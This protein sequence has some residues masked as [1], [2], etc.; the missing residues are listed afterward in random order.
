MRFLPLL[1]LLACVSVP[2]DP[3]VVDTG[4][5]PVTET[6]PTD[7]PDGGEQGADLMIL[8]PV[9][10]VDAASSRASAVGSRD[11]VIVY[12]G[13]AAGA[14]AWT[15]DGT[16]VVELAADQ[17][18]LPGLHDMHVHILE[19]FHPAITCVLNPAGP[20][21]MATQMSRCDVSPG[22]DWVLG[23]GHT[24]EDLEFASRNP[25][26]YLDD[27]FPNTPVAVM[28]L[29]SHS[30][31]VNSEALRRLGI[32]GDTAD[33]IGGVISRWSGQADGLL[34]D[35][36]GELPFDMALEANPAL[37][38][39]NVEALRAGL[40][41]A[42]RH[43]V[44]SLSDARAY[45]KRGYV[46]AWEQVRDE[47][48]LTVRASVGLWAYPTM[49]TGE[50]IDTLAAMYSDEPGARLRFN[51]VKLYSDG[52]VSNTT[53]AL[54]DPYSTETWAGSR[55]LNYFDEARLT[56]M[57]RELTAVGFDLHVHT[58]GDRAVHEALNAIEATAG[59]TARPPRHRLTHVE[60]VAPA[61]VSR[62]AKLGVIA[63]MQTSE[64]TLPEH[65]HDNDVFLGAD[66]VD[67]RSWPLR[68][69]HESGAQLTLS[70]DYDVGDMS[71]FKGMARAID[72][73]DQSLPDVDAAIRAYT[74]NAA[75]AMRQEDRVGSIEVG[76]LADLV[77]VD[78]DPVSTDALAGTKVLWTLVEGEPVYRRAGF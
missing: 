28:E 44:T 45:W 30:A 39:Q 17:V 8:G 5:P 46:E 11:G 42:N 71:P 70:S 77:V 13:D 73:G 66:R 3:Q 20:A 10:T 62:F 68:D 15:D 78:R 32:D 55:G 22:T 26:A 23:W 2:V 35:S 34:L 38:A 25:K 76:K 4:S 56:R 54:L 37:M 24:I 63:D 7:R 6:P 72:R 40:A 50:L 14:G 43:G 1:P 33:P 65:L 21:N 53:A 61:D 49:D 64:W 58:I 31:W 12:V 67:E 36:A 74:I 16:E 47:G 9:Y 51:Q 41:F 29:T 19:A 18:V 60:M 75:A 27:H 57:A 52:L 69:L 59:E 48:D